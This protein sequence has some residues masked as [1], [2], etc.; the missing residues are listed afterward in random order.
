[1]TET[2]TDIQLSDEI[3]QQFAVMASALEKY[4]PEGMEK[5]LSDIARANTVEDYNKILDGERQLPFDRLVRIDRV[6]YAESEFAAGLPF[7]LVLDGVDINAERTEQWVTGATTVVAMLVRAACMGH[8][9][10][11]GFAKESDKPTKSGYRPINWT[12]KEILGTGQLAA[13]PTAKGK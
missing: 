1:M 7:Y 3:V 8:L 5:I 6:R 10:V 12:M 13:T 4:D 9:P 11:V 2:G